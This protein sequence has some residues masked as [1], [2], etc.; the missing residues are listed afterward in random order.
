MF[1]GIFW[2]PLTIQ[3]LIFSA[4]MAQTRILHLE[5]DLD[6]LQYASDNIGG[7][8]NKNRDAL[9]ALLEGDSVWSAL[10]QVLL[11]SRRPSR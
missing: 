7:V 9:L 2:G 8:L 3:L 10:L 11:A 4:I 1:N 5:I 6:E